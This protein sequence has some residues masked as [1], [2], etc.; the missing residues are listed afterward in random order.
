M[1]HACAERRLRRDRH[2]RRRRGTV[3]LELAAAAGPLL[4]LVLGVMEVGYDMFVQEALDDAVNTAARLVFTGQ[5]TGAQGYAA[6]VRNAVCPAVSQI[7]ECQYLYVNVAPVAAGYDYYTMVPA[8][9]NPGQNTVCTGA[10]GQFM[11]LQAW[12]A[13]PTFLGALFPAFSGNVGGSLAHVTY[14][15]AGFVNE[16]FTGGQTC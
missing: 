1:E 8:V 9:L 14:T 15:S 6:F 3:A 16:Q 5:Q 7:L 12:Y 2:L 4:L 11:L 10:P 13:G